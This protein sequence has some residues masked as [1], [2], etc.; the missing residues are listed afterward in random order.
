MSKEWEKET[1]TKRRRW[2]GRERKEKRR[3]KPNECPMKREDDAKA[4]AKTVAAIGIWFKWSEIDVQNKNE[5]EIFAKYVV[6]EIRFNL[7]A[8]Q[9]E[10][11]EKHIQT[12]NSHYRPPLCCAY[13][14]SLCVCV[15]HTPRQWLYAIKIHKSV[16]HSLFALCTIY[17]SISRSP[18]AA[19]YLS[20]HAVCA[21]AHR[22]PF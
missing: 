4:A 17:F 9:A 10:R 19:V 3:P 7:F 14:V 11:R 6:Y 15:T 5:F 22:I 16:W 20:I 1:T 13:E 2:R 8:P 21:L 12:H 18:N